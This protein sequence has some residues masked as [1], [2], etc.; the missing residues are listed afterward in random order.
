[1]YGL[2]SGAYSEMKTR[3][4]PLVDGKHD[5]E[6]YQDGIYPS[7][8][9]NYFAGDHKDFKGS[10]QQDASEYLFHIMEIFDVIKDII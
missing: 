3:M 7:S 6:E 9:K 10:Q 5:I 1:M 4:L 8:F 2:Y